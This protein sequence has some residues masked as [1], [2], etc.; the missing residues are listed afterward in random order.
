M[1]NIIIKSIIT[2]KSIEQKNKNK[3]TVVV[4]KKANKNQIIDAIS[5]IFKLKVLFVNTCIYRGKN[6]RIGKY[7]GKLSNWK[8][9]ILTFNKNSNLDIFGD[10][11]K[12]EV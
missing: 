10:F 12:K 11:S 1:Y 6:K 8:K 9:A 5:K 3:I 2:E 4:S 7:S